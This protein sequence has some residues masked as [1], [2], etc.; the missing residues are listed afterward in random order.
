MEATM[1]KIQT[2]LKHRIIMLFILALASIVFTG[3]DKGSLGIKLGAIQSYVI[4]N[5]TNQPISE[6]MVRATGGLEDTEN[7]STYT[8]GDGSFI[9]GSCNK[10]SWKLTV[11]KFGYIPAEEGEITC[12]VANGETVVLSPIK[13]AKVASGTKGILKAY[14]ID[15]ITGRP[16]TNFTVTQ[17]SPYN[18]RKAKTFDTAA[19]FR[20]T[21]WTGLEGGD[22]TYSISCNNYKTFKTT[23]I[24]GLNEG[25][26]SIGKSPVDLGTIKIEPLTVSV[27]GTIR[28]LPGYVLDDLE[29]A[30]LTVWAE[31][32][33]K[34]VAT[35]T[36]FDDTGE[37]NIAAKLGN[38]NY[39]LYVPVTAGSVAVKCKLRGY[40]VVTISSAVSISN[41][42]TGGMI[43]G[44][45]IDF[46]TVE[47]IKTDLRV[48][49][50]GT[51]HEADNPSSFISGEV[52]RVYVKA[53]GND[54]VPYAECTSGE[55]TISGVITGYN[56]YVIVVNQN[57]KY[58]FKETD[59]FKIPE[60]TDIYPII[61]TLE[62]GN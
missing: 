39:Y 60:N 35:Y 4:D 55:V 40:D 43:S 54:V 15:A 32:G 36:K 14:P 28:N 48:I 26:V 7:K 25:I 1:V 9:F 6:V 56:I 34:V 33:G 29:N 46:S 57:K 31:S 30:E 21:G 49:V 18:E 16:L 51:K 13:M 10:G 47:P 3:C 61:V 27:S 50:T 5:E 17:E 22:H 58:C 53:G 41:T 38:V 62:S 59:A 45:D 24:E 20:D 12:N 19:N 52:A 2:I 44:V 11:E 37:S 8:D 23:D 42:N